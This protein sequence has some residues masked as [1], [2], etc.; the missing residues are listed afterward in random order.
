[1]KEKHDLSLWD[2]PRA[3][4]PLAA[5]TAWMLVQSPGVFDVW[6]PGSSMAGRV[7]IAAF[8]TIVLGALAKALGYQADQAGPPA[9]GQPA[10]EV[11]AGRRTHNKLT[12]SSPE[13]GDSI[14]R[15]KEREL[16]FAVPPPRRP[17]A[18]PRSHGVPRRDVPGRVHVSVAGETA[19]R[20]PET[21][22]ALAGPP[23]HVPARRAPL[24][25]VRGIDLLYP[26]GALSCSSAR[27][28]APARPQDLPVQPGFGPDVPAG[29]SQRAFR[30]RV[31]LVT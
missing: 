1:M 22:L 16:R 8:T 13:G 30:G 2:I 17:G 29:F 7:I 21:R 20:A 31:M 23:I 11:P 25:R 15:W 12:S 27:Q 28:Q 14:S 3:L 6:W 24:A 18:S 26:A 19:G 4:I 10:A 9:T 5:F